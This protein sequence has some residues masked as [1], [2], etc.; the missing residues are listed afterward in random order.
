MKALS[1][2]GATIDVM[3]SVD[4]QNIELITMHNSTTSY[5]MMEQGRKVETAHI[6]NYIGGGATNAAVAMARMGHETG[7]VLKI[8]TDLEGD[9]VL[10]KL[11]AE[12]IDCRHVLRTDERGTGKSIIVCSHDRN[13]GIF[14]HRGANTLFEEDD[15]SPEMFAGRDL[16]YVSTL[17]SGSAERYVQII[18]MAKEAGA[19]VVS[20][21]GIRQLRNRCPQI[22]EACPYIDLLAINAQEAAALAQGLGGDIVPAELRREDENLPKLIRHGL[23][24]KDFHVPLGAFCKT[25]HEKGVGHVLITNGAEGAYVSN[26]KAVLFRPAIKCEVASTIGAGDAFNATFATALA[27]K[28]SLFT[29]LNMAAVN[30]ASV[31]R[32]LDAQTGLLDGDKLKKRILSMDVSKIL[33]FPLSEGA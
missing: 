23:G 30:A 2:G 9:R 25:L 3:A 10:A 27:D 14:V 31:A 32:A 33:S 26:G 7:T 28:Q 11:Q 29:A 15:F 13:A 1:V 24:E 4:T 21:P 8:G 22:L 18:K 16:V 17:S 20:N 6:D 19:F 5:L 12:G